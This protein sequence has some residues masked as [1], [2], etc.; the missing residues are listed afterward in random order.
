MASRATTTK[1]LTRAECDGPPSRDDG[2]GAWGL[3]LASVTIRFRHDDRAVRM[4]ENIT[5]SAGVVE[6]TSRGKVAGP[7]A[8]GTLEQPPR[9][10]PADALTSP[11]R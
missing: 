4:A 10:S 9:T 1:G 3:M 8:R 5:S 11:L 6:R 2:R 7:G